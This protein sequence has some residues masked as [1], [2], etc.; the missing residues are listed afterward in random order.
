MMPR[1]PS[2]RTAAR[3]IAFAVAALG[4]TALL[5]HLVDDL[6][7]AMQPTAAHLQSPPTS[8][9]SDIG[10]DIGPMTAV[11][12]EDAEPGSLWLLWLPGLPLLAVALVFF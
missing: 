10:V 6:G 12:S 1:V 3:A 5:D 11:A 7:G 8:E 2:F 4:A 9:G